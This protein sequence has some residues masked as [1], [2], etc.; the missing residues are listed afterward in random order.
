MQLHGYDFCCQHRPPSAPVHH[1]KAWPRF[2][3]PFWA[4]ASELL[5]SCLA[6]KQAAR[7]AEPVPILGSAPHRRAA[8]LPPNKFGCSFSV[9]LVRF[10]G[11]A[12]W[13]RDCWLGATLCNVFATLFL[14]SFRG[15]ALSKEKVLTRT[16]A[17]NANNMNNMK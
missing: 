8:V 7:G 10:E 3:S 12:A 6:Q 11:C 14:F 5:E 1:A 16:E 4:A 2:P 9:G 17:W 13:F 15:F